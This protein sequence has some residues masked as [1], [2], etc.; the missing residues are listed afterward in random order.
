VKLGLFGGSFDPIHNGHLQTLSA[1]ARELA[2]DRVLLIPNPFPPHKPAE[3][4]TPYVH[5]REMVRL[6]LK[7]FPEFEL[8]TI[9]EESKG[10]AYT[11][12][13][14]RRVLETR[15]IS[16][17]DCWLVIGAD[18]LL[19][20]ES[21][22]DPEALYRDCTVAVM[23]RPGCDLARV[24]QRFL[25]RTRVLRSPEIDI[26][27]S[28]VRARVAA[29]EPIGHLVPQAVEAYIHSHKLYRP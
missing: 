7:V 25:T 15:G 18:A 10:P 19:E 9:E 22:K 13:T 5:R 8:A 2:L 16:P 26:S 23:P 24:P 3:R 17:E 27:A 6:A 29:G 12:D 1:A 4:L 11:T 21:W 20:L 28:D 14:V